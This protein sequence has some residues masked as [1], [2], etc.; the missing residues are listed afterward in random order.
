MADLAVLAVDDEKSIL[1]SLR[2][3]LRKE[4]YKLF[5]AESGAEGLEILAANEIRFSVNNRAPLGFMLVWFLIGR[6]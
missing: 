6:N 1:N 3:S 5:V 2:R 4:P